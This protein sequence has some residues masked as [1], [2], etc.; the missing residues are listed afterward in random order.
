MREVLSIFTPVIATIATAYIMA[1]LGL[2]LPE[3]FGVLEGI[4]Q[5]M[6]TAVLLSLTVSVYKYRCY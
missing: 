1:V 3:V 5:W 6:W 2:V 4:P